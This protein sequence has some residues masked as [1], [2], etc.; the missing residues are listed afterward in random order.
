VFSAPA[1]QAKNHS[2]E[3]VNSH[4][5]FCGNARLK[6]ISRQNTKIS[7]PKPNN[8]LPLKF[9]LPSSFQQITN[10]SL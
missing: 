6:N 10:S 2:R 8:I 3:P 7:Y 9:N 1:N 4:F 5:L